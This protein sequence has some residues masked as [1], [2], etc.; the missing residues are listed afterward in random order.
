MA[1]KKYTQP[2]KDKNKNAWKKVKKYR[3]FKLKNK[4]GESK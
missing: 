4:K 1:S 2:V 3:K